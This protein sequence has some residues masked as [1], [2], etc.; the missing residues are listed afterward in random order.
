MT[1]L[2]VQNSCFLTPPSV[3]IQLRTLVLP[4]YGDYIAW[5]K[6]EREGWVEGLLLPPSHPPPAGKRVFEQYTRS[7]SPAGKLVCQTGNK[8]P[9]PAYPIYCFWHV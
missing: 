4:H 3:M 8:R 1:T 5:G 2:D 9:N 7:L 6:G